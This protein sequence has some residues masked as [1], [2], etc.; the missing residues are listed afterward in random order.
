MGRYYSLKENRRKHVRTSI[1]KMFSFSL[2]NFQ[3]T[4]TRV[5]Y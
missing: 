4:K 1:Q 5:V 2:L 3:Y